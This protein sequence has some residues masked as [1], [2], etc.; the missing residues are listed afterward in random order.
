MWERAGVARD[1]AGGRARSGDRS[2]RADGSVH[3]P[4]AGA[5]QP[6]RA[7]GVSRAARSIPRMRARSAAALREA[8]GGGRPC[9]DADRAARLSRSL[10]DLF[11]LSHSADG[12]A[13]AAGFH[14]HAQSERGHRDVRSAARLS[15]DVRKIT[16]ATAANGKASSA[17]IT[18]CRS[19]TVTSG[20]S[21]RVSCATSTIGFTDD[22]P[23]ARTIDAP[24][25]SEGA[26]RDAARAL[27]NRDGE[28]AR[29]VGGAVR[30]GCS[31]FRSREIDVATTALP[32]EVMRRV[33]AAGGKAVPTGIEH[34]TVTAIIDHQ[35]VEVTTLRQDVET[36]G[37]KARVVFGRDWKADAERRDFTINALSAGAGRR[38]CTTMSAALPTSPRSACASSASRSSGSKKTICAFCASS[39]FTRISAQARPMP[40]A[41]T[42]ASSAAPAS[43]RCRANACAWSCSSFCSRRARRADARGHGRERAA[44]APSSAASR[45]SR[46]SRT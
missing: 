15:D 14:A 8:Q 29:V 3:D 7:G 6:R 32:D 17:N 10:F 18:R 27:L 46:A 9:A 40:P 39:A 26:G 21:P 13:R 38:W 33:E 41:C 25:L 23:V 44:W 12:R 4:H 11:G 34:G 37:R 19:A 43:I 16:S 31:G 2:R 36:F 42:P 1:Q 35:P 24:W 22:R 45:I 20:V 30:N 5:C 28:E